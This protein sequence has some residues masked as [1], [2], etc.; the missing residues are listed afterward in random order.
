MELEDFFAY[1]NF[2][3]GQKEF[4]ANIYNAC[5][6][7][8]TLVAEAMSGFGK[9][10]AALSGSMLAARER[11]LR[12]VY[13][14]RTHREVFR[15]V[16][17]ISKLQRKSRITAGCL[18]SKLDYCLLKRTAH[19]SIPAESFKWYCNFHVN[20]NLC[21]Y[22][23]NVSLLSSRVSELA[24]DLSTNLPKQEVLLKESEELHVCPY[25]VARLVLN[26]AEVIVVTYHYLFEETSR[27][28]LIN[29]TQLNPGKTI[30]ILDEAHNLRD[31]LRTLSSWKL[32]LQDLN[33]ASTEAEGLGL[34]NLAKSIHIVTERAKEV[35]RRSD[36]WWIDKQRFVESIT[37]SLGVVWLSN[38]SLE[39]SGGAGITSYSIAEGSSLPLSMVRLSSFLTN[40][41]SSLKIDHVVL[42]RTPDGFGLVDVDP[43]R[44]FHKVAG[45]FYSTIL[46]SATISPSRLFLESIGLDKTTLVHRTELIQPLVRTILDTGVTTRYKARNA[47]MYSRIVGKIVSTASAIDGGIGVFVPSYSVLEALASQLRE[48]L[49]G[50][51]LLTEQRGLKN[52]RANEII[53]EF[54]SKTGSILLAVQGGRFSEG[55]D[56]QG[57]QMEASIV[58]GLAMPPPTPAMYAEYDYLKKTKAEASYL[59]VS[60]IPALRKAFQ[61][62]GRHLR[63]PDKKGLVLLLDSRF[64]RETAIDLMPSWLKQNITIGN[65]SAEQ[66]KELAKQFVLN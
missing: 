3:T 25:E 48:K 12:I 53:E 45:E 30:L 42:T 11:N 47:D 56:F 31:F 20:N 54:K 28:V 22:F 49:G 51:L 19:Y 10:A 24:Q 62:A 29:N 26:I 14:C 39:I 43:A 44:S 50:R 34:E 38:T 35:H 40:L 17:E 36:D 60:L 1:E 23:L 16:E 57:N 33:Q 37:Y 41:L 64:A 8:S 15:V 32:S 58:V 2:R 63:S 61:S 21:S 66:L 52:Q 6:K 4:A 59:L 46:I 27:S 55:E 13:A 18:S 7:R 5:S 9:T 65:F